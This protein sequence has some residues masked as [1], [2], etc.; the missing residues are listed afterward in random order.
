MKTPTA[1]D[2]IRLA[3]D[4]FHR[5][6]VWVRGPYEIDHPVHGRCGCVSWALHRAADKLISYGADET[7]CL[8]DEADDLLSGAARKLGFRKGWISANDVDAKRKRDVERIF[9]EAGK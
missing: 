9:E 5:Q 8:L 3:G 6:R 7:Y 1:K 2:V 4:I